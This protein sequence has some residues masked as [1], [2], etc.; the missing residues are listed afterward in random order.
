[1]LRLKRNKKTLSFSLVKRSFL[2]RALVLALIYSLAFHL[3]VF[4]VFRIKMLEVEEIPQSP[5]VAVVIDKELV[6]NTAQADSLYEQSVATPLITEYLDDEVWLPST[7]YFTDTKFHDA[8][9]TTISHIFSDETVFRSLKEIPYTLRAYPIK[10]KCSSSLKALKIVEDGSAL[11]KKKENAQFLA[12]SPNRT[13]IEYVLEVDGQT[14]E[15]LSWTKPYEL[16][17]KKLARL[18]NHL[19]DSIRFLPQDTNIY[20][21]SLYITFYCTGEEIK[22]FLIN[23]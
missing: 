11:F 13:R 18:A 6:S 19:I 21:G 3:V 17:D 9:E 8:V 1:M 4:V 20:K 10:L 14:G 5:P 7:S 2:D 12:H 23:P 22:E 15:I 16:L